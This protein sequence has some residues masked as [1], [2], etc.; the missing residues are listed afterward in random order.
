MNTDFQNILKQLGKQAQKEAA[1]K[2]AA[3]KN[4]QKQEQD[5][6]FSQ[7]VGQVSPLKTGSNIMRRPTNPPSKSV[8]KTTAPTKKTTST[9]AAHT[10]TR[11]PASAKTDREKTTPNA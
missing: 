3:E 10:T 6:D 11:P 7:A 5:F 2:Q 4:K 1:E 9:S 8:P